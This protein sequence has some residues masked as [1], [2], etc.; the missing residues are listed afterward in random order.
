MR[1]RTLVRSFLLQVL[2]SLR[3][4]YGTCF[5]ITGKVIDDARARS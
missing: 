1:I 5:C 4:S 2:Y 3:I